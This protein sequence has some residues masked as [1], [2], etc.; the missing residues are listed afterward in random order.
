[1]PRLWPSTSGHCRHPPS[2][3]YTTPRSSPSVLRGTTATIRF[4]Y[5]IG[6][7]MPTPFARWRCLGPLGLLLVRWKTSL[8]LRVKMVMAMSTHVHGCRYN[9]SPKMRVGMVMTV[10]RHLHRHHSRSKALTVADMGVRLMYILASQTV[11]V[12]SFRM[13]MHSLLQSQ[14]PRPKQPQFP[15]HVSPSQSA[16]TAEQ[17]AAREASGAE[18]VT[19]VATDP[20]TLEAA[21]HMASVQGPGG[22]PERSSAPAGGHA[23]AQGSSAEQQSTAELAAISNVDTTTAGTQE[24]LPQAGLALPQPDC[25]SGKETHIH[26]EHPGNVTSHDDL[27]PTTETR[28]LFPSLD[29]GFVP[30]GGPNGDSCDDAPK[31]LVAPASH[32]GGTD[33]Q[34]ELSLVPSG[35]GLHLRIDPVSYPAQGP[36]TI[37]PVE[38][39]IHPGTYQTFLVSFTSDAPAAHAGHFFGMCALADPPW[40]PASPRGISRAAV[41]GGPAPR[42]NSSH[43]SLQSSG[44]SCSIQPHSSAPQSTHAAFPCNT[45]QLV[46][47]GVGT[48]APVDPEPAGVEWGPSSRS[49]ATSPHRYWHQLH[50]P[51]AA[52]RDPTTP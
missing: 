41:E 12:H 35:L 43:S 45:S 40:K 49:H 42:R 18:H 8:K 28:T 37:Q 21:T 34:V 11:K 3:L 9:L 15:R 2:K 26:E 46:V 25:F 6:L 31:P 10:A 29:S 27:N 30:T 19:K 39:T 33:R 13:R 1:M 5:Q 20:L 52:R 17:G 50:H 24:P 14:G 22:D 38:A 51:P 48:L 44:P 16:S 7:G 23:L 32:M 47:V 4:R 36:F